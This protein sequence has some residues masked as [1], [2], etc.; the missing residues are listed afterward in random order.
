MQKPQ[1]KLTQTIQQR[2]ELKTVGK[3]SAF[4]TTSRTVEHA[5]FSTGRP[6]LAAAVIFSRRDW[7]CP[8]AG[9]ATHS[10][11]MAQ[12]VRNLKPGQPLCLR[13][14]PWPD[15]VDEASTALIGA[16]YSAFWKT[17]PPHDEGSRTI[18]KRA[19]EVKMPTL[20][21]RRPCL[22]R[23]DRADHSRGRRPIL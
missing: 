13:G 8:G 18:V 6:T 10:A 5:V 16:L 3:S 21:C 19:V 11:P 7:R 9:H 14:F 15:D 12:Q 20:V 23:L 1:G 4:P 22:R 17:K 2:R